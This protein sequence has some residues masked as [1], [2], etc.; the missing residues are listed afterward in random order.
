V[1]IKGALGIFAGNR[2]H[3][4]GVC[5]QHGNVFLDQISRRLDSDTRTAGI[6]G[7]R[8]VVVAAPAGMEYDDRIFCGVIVLNEP[9]SSSAPHLEGHH[10]GTME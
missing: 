3:R 7:R 8:I 10:N 5:A 1:D 4:P 6:I 9:F 2:I